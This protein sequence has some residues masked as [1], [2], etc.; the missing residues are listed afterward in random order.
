MVVVVATAL[1]V[2]KPTEPVVVVVGVRALTVLMVQF[3]RGHI[4][5]FGFR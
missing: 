3:W 5:Q 1:L 2:G 4:N